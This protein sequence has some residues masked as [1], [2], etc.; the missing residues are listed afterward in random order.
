MQTLARGLQI[1]DLI[2]NADHALRVTEIAILLNLDKSSVSRMVRTLAN[3][4]YIQQDAH[5]RGYILGR[6][7]HQNSWR[8]FNRMSFRDEGRPYLH[9]LVEQTGECAH[10]AVYSDGKA[11]M[12]DDVES[13][14]SLRVVGGVGRLIP[15]HCTAVGKALLA[16]SDLPCPTQLDGYTAH[17]ITD[18]AQL[19][20]HLDLIREQQYALDDEEH[21]EG[22][23][24]LA[25]PVYNSMGVLVATIGISGPT[26]RITDERISELAQYVM[27]AAR[28]LSD[29][30]RS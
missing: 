9:R 2:A 20:A 11:L 27:S 15:L 7:F 6:R 23:R 8:Y 17:T 4:E 12:V 30:L 29:E 26:V 5:S 13:Q 22:A 21:Q 28:E 16:F 24:C 18:R 10:L 14:A 3:Y 25:A 1:L 19:S